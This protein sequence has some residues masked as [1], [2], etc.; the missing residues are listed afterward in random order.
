MLF[1]NTVRSW[2]ATAQKTKACMM[3]INAG[4]MW[5]ADIT[6]TDGTASKKRPVLVL[7]LDGNDATTKFQLTLCQSNAPT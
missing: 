4:E 2:T 6:Y 5:V 1:A 3:N 7:W